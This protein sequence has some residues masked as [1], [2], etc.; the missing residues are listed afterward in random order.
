VGAVELEPIAGSPTKR[1]GQAF[2]AAFDKGVLIR[3]TGDTIALSPPLIVE[4]SQIDQIAETLREV[5]KAV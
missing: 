4:K 2:G 3:T 1:A 5:L